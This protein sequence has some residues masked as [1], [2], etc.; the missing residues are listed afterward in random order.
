MYFF[1][2]IRLVEISVGFLIHIMGSS[3]QLF[4]V[5]G[6]KTFPNLVVPLHE[7][8]VKQIDLIIALLHIQAE[9]ITFNH[10]PLRFGCIVENRWVV[11]NVFDIFEI[12][13]RLQSGVTHCCPHCHVQPFVMQLAPFMLVNLLYQRRLFV[14]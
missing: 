10:C 3:R 8:L 7:N 2:R 4:T 14:R 13:N 6:Y 11:F 9:V 1:N 12:R 5:H